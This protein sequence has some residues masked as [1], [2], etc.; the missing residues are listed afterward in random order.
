MDAIIHGVIDLIED[1]RA[2]REA[3]RAWSGDTHLPMGV[4]TKVPQL[5]PIP[6]LAFEKRIKFRMDFPEEIAMLDCE[7]MGFE[8]I[9][10][11]R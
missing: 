5:K 6:L 2:P 8:S 7:R 11:D 3:L 1:L 4:E 10:A 9:D